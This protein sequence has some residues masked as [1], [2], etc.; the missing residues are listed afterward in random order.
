[1]LSKAMFFICISLGVLSGCSRVT[2]NVHDSYSCPGSVEQAEGLAKLPYTDDDLMRAAVRGPGEGGICRGEV[3]VVQ[4]PVF[5]YRVWDKNN[6]RSRTGRWWTFEEPKGP[7][8]RW[9]AKYAVCPEWKTDTVTYVVSRCQIKKGTKIVVGPG[10]S[11]RCKDSAYEASPTNQ[12]YI[13]NHLSTD[14]DNLNE[15]KEADYVE[16]CDEGSEWP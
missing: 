6:S 14:A 3:F 9:R 10:Q 5:A 13:P 7:L 11:I 2:V 15:P 16:N 12:V 4:K 8:E 1:M